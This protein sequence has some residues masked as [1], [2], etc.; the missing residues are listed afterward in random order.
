MLFA[1]LLFAD[2]YGD[3]SVFLTS[4]YTA[5][6]NFITVNSYFYDDTSEGPLGVPENGSVIV[7]EIFYGGSST[8]EEQLTDFDVFTPDT[9][10]DDILLSFFDDPM[11][12]LIY[13]DYQA[14]EAAY[15]L[16][17][18]NLLSWD[19]EPGKGLQGGQ[20]SVLVVFSEDSMAEYSSAAFFTQ[21]EDGAIGAGVL[22][23][24]V[25]S[26]VPNPSGLALMSLTLLSTG[27]RRKS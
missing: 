22:E 9:A 1:A 14:P 25:P 13:E 4:S 3:P 12:D 18:T 27:R 7:Y 15:N 17:Q 20:T 6:N 8:E 26:M 11:G 10:S 23:V 2:I 16:A 21:S 19:W 24:L 5:E